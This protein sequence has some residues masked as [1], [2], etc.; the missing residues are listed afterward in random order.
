MR[1]RRGGGGLL[2][3]VGGV[4]SVPCLGGISARFLPG[5]ITP[6]L[7]QSNEAVLFLPSL[8]EPELT[9]EV[10]SRTKV[11]M[12]T[13]FSLLS[14]CASGQLSCSHCRAGPLHTLYSQLLLSYNFC[15]YVTLTPALTL[16]ALT[17]PAPGPARH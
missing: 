13:S 5:A 6:A 14:L 3:R 10:P 8:A 17:G 15:L 2:T 16:Q 11:S 9:S 4:S 1:L 7:H 12:V